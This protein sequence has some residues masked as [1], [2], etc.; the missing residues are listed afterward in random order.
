MEH[1]LH[2]HY[3]N[4]GK[5]CEPEAYGAPG[6]KEPMPAAPASMTSDDGYHDISAQSEFAQRHGLP[7]VSKTPDNVTGTVESSNPTAAEGAAGPDGY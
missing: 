5:T 3:P 2:E 7:A 6:Q 4:D 1:H